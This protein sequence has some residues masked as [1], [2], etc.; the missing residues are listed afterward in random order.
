MLTVSME[1]WRITQ[2]KVSVCPLAL[3]AQTQ[4]PFLNEPRRMRRGWATFGGKVPSPTIWGALDTMRSH[5][6]WSPRFSCPRPS[7]P[8]KPIVWGVTK[9]NKSEIVTQNLT[10]QHCPMVLEFEIRVFLTVDCSFGQKVATPPAT[11]ET[12]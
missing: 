4:I 7:R 8:H 3:A 11:D 5:F 2:T 6:L 10:L 12:S 9:Q 1:K